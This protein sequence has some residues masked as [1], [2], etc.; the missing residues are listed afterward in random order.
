MFPFAVVLLLA[1]LGW[2]PSTLGGRQWIARRI[3]L[4]KGV[5]QSVYKLQLLALDQGALNST[6]P[7]A[8]KSRRLAASAVSIP[9]P[10]RGLPLSS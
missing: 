5:A 10:T 1:L 6:L 2:P 3:G 4:Q 9:S 7:A 8:L